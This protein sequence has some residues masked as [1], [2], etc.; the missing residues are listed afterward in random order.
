MSKGL[1]HRAT[2]DARAASLLALGKVMAGED[3]QAALDAVL[4]ASSLPPSD[5]ALATELF[6][7]TLR[8]HLRLDWFLRQK[9]AKPEGIPAEMLL[10]LEQTMYELAHTRIPAHAGV[11]WAAGLVRARFGPGLAKV[12]NGVLR[13]FERGKQAEYLNMAWYAGRLGVEPESA[14]AQAAWYGLPLWLARLWR[15][16]Y[17]EETYRCLLEASQ[18]SAPQALRLNSARP[19]AQEALKLLQEQGAEPLPP[20]AWILPKNVRLPVNVWIKNGLASRQSAAAHAAL[21]ALAP[22]S[23][24]APLWDACAGRG[25]KSLALLEQGLPVAAASDPSRGRLNG[26]DED[27]ARL[28]LKN[29]P[30]PEIFHFTAQDSGFEK[31]FRSVLVDAPCSGLGTLAHRP[32]IRWRRKPDDIEKLA[33]LQAEILE[34]AHRAL[35]PEAGSAIIY[36]TC[37]MTRRENQEQAAAFL[38]RHQEYLME[39][40]YASPTEASAWGRGYG[41]F[42]YG[43]L[44]RR[45]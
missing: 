1:K 2:G 8:R 7:G 18:E 30:C 10:A 17:P 34:A 36:L 6:Y 16:S 4:A 39:R 14:E 45:R 23:W 3:S 5:K 31:K 13:G 38:S 42:F 40:E 19:E 35:A 43:A 27:F 26:L 12:A 20:S 28:G 11:N 33:A 25:G 29:P 44:L 41:E 37:T 32:E 15:E 24:P 9:L 21:F 22:A